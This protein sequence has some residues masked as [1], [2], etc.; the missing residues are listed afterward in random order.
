ELVYSLPRVVK[1]CVPGILARHHQKANGDG[2]AYQRARQDQNASQN[3]QSSLHALLRRYASA[4]FESSPT[5]AAISECASAL[6]GER[7]VIIFAT[8]IAETIT[9]VIP[10]PGWVQ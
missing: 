5:A 3:L 2:Y 8:R 4:L 10:P 6:N 1:A 7:S 9:G